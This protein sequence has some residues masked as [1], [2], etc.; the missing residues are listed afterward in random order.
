M[1]VKMNDKSFNEKK[2]FLKNRRLRAHKK[3]LLTGGI[4]AV[5]AITGIIA[6]VYL[7]DVDIYPSHD[8]IVP[9][10]EPVPLDQIVKIGLLG[11]MN[12]ISGDH[13]WKGAL[14][15]ARE[16]NEGG[17]ILV[18]GTQYYM[19]LVSENT[20]EVYGDVSE[21]VIA[22]ENMI[23]NH[24]PHF[25]T[26]GLEYWAIYDYLEVIMKK[27]IPFISTG[28]STWDL[29]QNVLDNYERYKYIFRVMPANDTGIFYDIFWKIMSLTNH[30]NLTY[31][32]TV[33]KIAFLREKSAWADTMTDGFKTVLQSYGLTVEDIKF[34]LNATL[35][36]FKTCWND[37]EAAGTQI[38]CILNINRKKQLGALITQAYQSLK[39]RCLLFSAVNIIAQTSFPYWDDTKGACQYEV[40]Y[41]GMYN[42][43]KTNLTIPFFN[44]FVRKYGIEPFFT[45]WGSY[46]AVNLLAYAVNDSQS[47][48]SDTIVKTLEKI[49]VSNPF[50]TPGGYIAFTPSHYLRVRYPFA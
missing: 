19:G 42:T 6:G 23:N 32:G 47:F 7:F 43:S 2:K 16:I 18:N 37:I 34:P 1:R 8:Y 9:G 49:N 38:T 41:Q 28:T 15:A 21:G 31:G 5:V 30:L 20:N 29:C 44:S 35:A 26:G 39:P 22:A 11:D 3:Q 27:E 25:I 12:H 45:G 46:G 17:G 10:V 48:K 40:V 36:D 33:D 50:T 4:I 14:L 24:H 13:A